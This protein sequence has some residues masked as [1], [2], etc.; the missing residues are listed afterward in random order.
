[1]IFWNAVVAIV[2][3]S[4]MTT[5]LPLTPVLSPSN[6]QVSEAVPTAHNIDT[7]LVMHSDVG[8]TLALP[9]HDVPV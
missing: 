6:V 2:P 8:A 3:V 4:T 5:R 7:A 9:V 1:M